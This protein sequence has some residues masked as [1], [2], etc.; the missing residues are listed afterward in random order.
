[1]TVVAG[2]IIAG[3]L[4]AGTAT[5]EDYYPARALNEEVQGV[6]TIDCVVQQNGSLALCV[7]VSEGPRGYGFGAA[8]IKA[9]SKTYNVKEHPEL[10]QPHDPGD[11]IQLTYHWTL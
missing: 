11:H 6:A 3:L 8:T 9:F 10:T 2:Y 5:K 1:M 4:L 7:I